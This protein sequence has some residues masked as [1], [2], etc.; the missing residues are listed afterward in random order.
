MKIKYP[1]RLTLITICILLFSWG[2]IVQILHIIN[3]DLHVQIKEEE[4]IR[5]EV[6]EELEQENSAKKEEKIK[7]ENRI[8]EF[9]SSTIIIGN[10]EVMTKDLEEKLNW[11][12][13]FQACLV[14]KEGWRLP[15]KSEIQML[16][17]N[18][19]KIG[20]FAQLYYWSSTEH[21]N[22]RAWAQ[23]FGNHGGHLGHSSKRNEQWIRLVRTKKN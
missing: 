1:F 4:R 2:I 19:N 6:R 11:D 5:M 8:K 12:K 16:F 22:N 13:A 7:E 10:L 20:G 21:G 23:H 17:R 15:T 3:S 18:K 14:F 9:K